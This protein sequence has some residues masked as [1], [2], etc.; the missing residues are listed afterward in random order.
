MP[1]SASCFAVTRSATESRAAWATQSLRQDVPL[2]AAEGEGD[3]TEGRAG[4]SPDRGDGYE[5][6]HDD[7]RQHDCI[8]HC[9]G[10]VFRLHKPANSLQKRFHVDHLSSANPLRAGFCPQPIAPMPCC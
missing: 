10:S 4:L 1:R 6:H 5:A 7:Q 3:I 2:A 8:L 9:S